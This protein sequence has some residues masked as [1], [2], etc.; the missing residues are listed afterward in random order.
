MIDLGE[1][2]DIR[3]FAYLARQDGGWNGAFA[4]T[5]FAISE[6][7]KTFDETAA[8][9]TFSKVRKAQIVE[10]PKPIRGRFVRIRALSEVNGM[11]WGSAA[12][13]GVLGT[14]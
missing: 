4:K 6:S 10:L 5:E 14:R 7:D 11:A 12:E 13:I 2:Y 9:T 1:V 8:T 3:G